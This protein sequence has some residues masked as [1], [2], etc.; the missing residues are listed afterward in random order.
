VSGYYSKTSGFFALQQ[1][2]DASVCDD[3]LP[4]VEQPNVYNDFIWRHRVMVQAA[5]ALTLL[6]LG[7]QRGADLFIAEWDKPGSWQIRLAAIFYAPA[8]L[9]LPGTTD[10]IKRIQTKYYGFAL[11]NKNIQRPARL[12]FICQALG[13]IGTPKACDQL[14][15]LLNWPSR[16]V[17]GAALTALLKAAPTPENIQLV[18]KTVQ[19]DNTSFVQ[20]RAAQ[21]LYACGQPGQVELI[22]RLAGSCPESFEQAVAIEALGILQQKDCTPLFIKGLSQA[23]PYVRTC[24]IEALDRIQA[25][26][27]LPLIHKM[28]DDSN[29]IVRLQ[30]AKGIISMETGTA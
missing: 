1:I 15:W 4:L 29:P 26:A 27:H 9:S 13:T 22:K 24:A 3:I 20:L 12:Y 19:E 14:K 6:K 16:Y 18:T 23:N 2:G 7:D 21:A 8:I 10:I 17:R 30:A 5:C 25:A 11:Y 28:L